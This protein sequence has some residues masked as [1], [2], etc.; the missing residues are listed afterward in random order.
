MLAVG[1]VAVLV[2]VSKQE[3]DG[4]YAFKRNF[5]GAALKVIASKPRDKEIVSLSG[6]TL[7][8]I[9]FQTATPGN[10]IKS[11]FYL[12]ASQTISTALPTDT[13]TSS[14]FTL[15][16]DS[17]QVYLFA[18]NV[19]AI[20]SSS[21]TG[22]DLSAVKK[23]LFPMSL[24]SRGVAV[25]Q[26]RFVLRA[27]DTARS[28]DQHFMLFDALDYS[29]KSE[30]NITDSTGN[31]GIETDG[32]LL[33]DDASKLIVYIHYYRSSFICMDTAL[34]LVY[35]S[36][37]TDTLRGV[38]TKANAVVSAKGLFFTNVTP[39]RIIN[40]SACVCNGKLYIHSLLRAS[41]ESGKSFV[42][43]AVID[44]YDIRDG[45]YLH[46]FYIPSYN[47]QSLQEFKVSGNYLIALFKT[48]IT[49]FRTQ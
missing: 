3:I 21:L 8:N 16:V 30:K 13:K 28:F 1:I 42:K 37:L 38:A 2:S 27:Y 12:K 36:A 41:N 48:E 29:V 49:V 14:A 4:A 46:S 19:P 11:D 24:F 39:G 40:S 25:N 33:Y 32:I 44:V 10:I 43:N 26:N 47:Q 22:T 35:K 5:V 7:S 9:Y 18:A 45:S 31:A 20:Y 6:A 23:Y 17:P 15:A 34:N